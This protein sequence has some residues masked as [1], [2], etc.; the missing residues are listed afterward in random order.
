MSR[1]PHPCS[2]SK[3]AAGSLF[4]TDMEMF[5]YSTALPHHQA[6]H[7][8]GP[9]SGIMPASGPASMALPGITACLLVGTPHVSGC[10]LQGQ[11][12]KAGPRGPERS[13][14]MK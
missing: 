6:A 7:P 2:Y 8:A 10:D 5:L 1:D 14:A 11:A 3:T 12:K 13:P 9:A 4:L